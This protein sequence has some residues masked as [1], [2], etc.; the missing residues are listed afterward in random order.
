MTGFISRWKYGW[1]AL[2]AIK[3][4]HNHAECISRSLSWSRS[5]QISSHYLFLFH[6]LWSKVFK[7]WREIVEGSSICNCPDMPWW[8]SI[9]NVMNSDGHLWQRS[10]TSF[11][12][13]AR[14]DTNGLLW[15]KSWYFILFYFIL[16]YFILFYFMTCKSGHLSEKKDRTRR[17][18]FFTSNT[19]ESW[20]A[21]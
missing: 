1:Q 21:L 10:E 8:L 12:K 5:S 2:C 3:R 11:S 13:T 6:C 17:T 14:N 16:F 15:R 7:V 9:V 18:F 20:S 4:C 19:P